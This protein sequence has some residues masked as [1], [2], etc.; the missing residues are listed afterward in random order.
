M[1][2]TDD[3]RV[4]SSLPIEFYEDAY[5]D[6]PNYDEVV[7]CEDCSR[8]Y[9]IE[10][11]RRGGDVRVGWPFFGSKYTRV[12]AKYTL[13]QFKYTE[14]TQVDTDEVDSLGV[15]VGSETNDYVRSAPGWEWRSGL[16]TTLVRRTTD[17]R[18]HPR[19]GSYMRFT[20]DAFG[21]AF[22]GDVEYQRYILD[23]RTYRPAFWNVTL[24]LRGRAGIVT[25]YGD[26]STV[27]NDT[28][29]EMGGVGLNGIRGYDNRSI[30]P[31]GSEL[32]GGRTMVLGSAELKLPLTNEREQMPVYGLV[33]V[34][35]GNTWDSWEDTDPSDLYWGAG[36]GVRVE[37]PVLGNLGI[38]MGYG[39]DEEE[40]GEWIVHYQFGLAY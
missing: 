18:F 6:D 40:G 30:L 36:A 21:W 1:Y 7:S 3:K 11:E 24:M 32:Y 12:Y 34:D 39:F 4:Y 27:P 9:I 28:R 20:A 35:A 31:E 26:P 19:L 22:G 8:H 17:R 33:F 25:G 15:V 37:V 38:D 14:Y 13:E 10:R 16:T 23:A 2:D 29:F 5:E